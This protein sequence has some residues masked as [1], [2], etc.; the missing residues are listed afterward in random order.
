LELV[1]NIVT[2]VFQ[3]IFREKIYINNIFLFFQNYF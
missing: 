1:E 3:I 2:V